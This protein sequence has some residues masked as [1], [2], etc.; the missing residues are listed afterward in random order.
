MPRKPRLF[1]SGGIY[2]VYCETSGCSRPFA[3]IT[4]NGRLPA[5]VFLCRS[6]RRIA[7]SEVLAGVWRPIPWSS[8]E[9]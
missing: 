5:T 3:P 4:R 7:V 9:S 1:V 8:Q 2:Y 6:R